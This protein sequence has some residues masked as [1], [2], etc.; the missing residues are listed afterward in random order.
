MA[1]HFLDNQ[2]QPSLREVVL[3]TISGTRVKIL[4]DER[5]DAE[6]KAMRVFFALIYKA[7]KPSSDVGVRSHG[8]MS[9]TEYATTFALRFGDAHF[10]FNL[11]EKKKLLTFCDDCEFEL[12]WNFS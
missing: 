6:A 2:I 8:S 5:N 7:R 12:D 11:T 10:L 3:S 9:A 1:T 4:T